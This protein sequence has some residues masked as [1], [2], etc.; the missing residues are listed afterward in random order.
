MR[1]KVGYIFICIVTVLLKL[2]MRIYLKSEGK[3]FQK[4]RKVLNVSDV[5]SLLIS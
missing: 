3:Y 2:S 4:L 1:E 5:F